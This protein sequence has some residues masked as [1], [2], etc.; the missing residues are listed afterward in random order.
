[1]NAE[2]AIKAIRNNWP[3]D[4]YTMLREALTLSIKL[5]DEKIKSERELTPTELKERVYKPVFAIFNTGDRAWYILDDVGTF[6]GHMY[7]TLGSLNYY[8]YKVKLYTREPNK[9][10]VK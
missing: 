1:M 5:L 4:N 6:N 3:P 2:Q 9:E 8:A 7:V 10:E